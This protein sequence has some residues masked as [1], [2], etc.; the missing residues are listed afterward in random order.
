MLPLLCRS[1]VEAAASLD[2][3]GSNTS[4]MVDLGVRSGTKWTP[5]SKCTASGIVMAPLQAPSALKEARVGLGAS[6]TAVH[7]GDGNKLANE[8]FCI[9]PRD[10]VVDIYPD[11]A[12]V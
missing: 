6:Y 8:S 4:R 3:C 1:A 5:H 11:S 2:R 7:A 10:R 9:G 12:S